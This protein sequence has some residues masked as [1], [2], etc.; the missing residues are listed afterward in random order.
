MLWLEQM[1][2]GKGDLSFKRLATAAASAAVAESVT[3]PID[4]V[5]TWLQLQGD[6][7]AGRCSPASRVNTLRHVVREGGIRGVYAGLGAAVLRHVPYTTTRIIVFET[8]SSRLGKER[9]TSADTLTG[10]AARVVSTFGLG[11]VAGGVA[12]FIATP[13]DLVKVRTIG[14]ASKP[15]Q[16]RRYTKGVFDALCRIHREQ[17]LKGMWTGAMPAVQRAALV[18]LGELSTYDLAKTKI[19]ESGMYAGDAIQTHITSSL[20]SGIVSSLISTP[21]D[22]VK[23]RMMN[24]GRSGSKMM[25]TGSMHCLRVCWREE[26]IR[27]LYRGLLP[28]YLR[29]GPWQ[30]TFWVTYE[31]LN[32]TLHS[33]DI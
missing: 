24:Q 4:F 18:N 10:S 7:R 30:L 6:S 16:E 12:Q 15:L 23:T 2:Q 26:G 33:L 8:L 25:Y 13:L 17:G 14:D 3:F 19:V 27:G 29:L 22:V 28:T 20:L 21:A 11:F 31:Q 32:S 9:K 1:S 5:K